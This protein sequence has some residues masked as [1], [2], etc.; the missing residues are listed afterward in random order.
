MSIMPLWRKA[1]NDLCITLYIKK[2]V[3]KDEILH[4]YRIFSSSMRW[5]WYWLQREYN[6]LV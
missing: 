3:V 5:S 6:W 4:I 2:K 1:Q